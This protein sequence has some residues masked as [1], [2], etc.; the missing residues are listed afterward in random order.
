MKLVRWC[1]LFLLAEFF[2]ACWWFWGLKM[3]SLSTIGVVLLC[4]IFGCVLNK[5]PVYRA[6][7]G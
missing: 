3:A 6:P 4:F 5:A 1:F 7:P 2:A